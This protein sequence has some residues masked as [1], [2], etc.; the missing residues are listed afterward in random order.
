MPSVLSALTQLDFDPW[1][2]AAELARLSG[3]MASRR[4]ASRL[5]SLPD[6]PSAPRDV[7]RI[8]ARLVALL[9]RPSTINIPARATS[10]GVG[11]STK[12]SVGSRPILVAILIAFVLGLLWIA[13]R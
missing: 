3:A 6:R 10:I 9:P 8:A 12:F 11:A 7:E 13:S 4:L 1:Q 5:A 2:E